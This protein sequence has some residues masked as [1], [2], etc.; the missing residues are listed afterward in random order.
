MIDCITTLHD[1]D[2]MLILNDVEFL[3][4]TH[5]LLGMHAVCLRPAAGVALC[6]LYV[7]PSC[8]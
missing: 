1:L 4:G 5:A 7:F 6:S 8:T 3:A 2:V